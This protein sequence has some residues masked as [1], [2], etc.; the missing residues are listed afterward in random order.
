[1]NYLEKVLFVGRYISKHFTLEDNS[2]TF[3][4]YKYLI[5]YIVHVFYEYASVN[6][7]NPHASFV[8]KH[9]L[10]HYRYSYAHSQKISTSQ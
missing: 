2:D 10:H 8:P 5:V 4:R 1:M 7:R 9:V 3:S 6:A